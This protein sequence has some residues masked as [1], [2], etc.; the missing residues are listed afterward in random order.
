MTFDLPVVQPRRRH[1]PMTPEADLFVSYP[2][3]LVSLSRRLR[4]R[5]APQ[6]PHNYAGLRISERPAI[7]AAALGRY[8]P[9]KSY[10]RWAYYD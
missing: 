8:A 2:S 9:S 6:T 4:A 7:V 1:Q 3:S 5:F 10:I